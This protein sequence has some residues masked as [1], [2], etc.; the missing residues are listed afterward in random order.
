MQCAESVLETGLQKCGEFLTFF[1]CESWI[2]M[3]CL[4]ILQVYLFMRHI[5][6]TAED[7]RLLLVL[8][9]NVAQEVVFPLH[10]VV[11]AFQSVLSVG[12]IYCDEEEVFIL[13]CYNSSLMV[14]FF[15]ADAI[16]N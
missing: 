6:V 10:A 8:F 3:V 11:K 13:Q 4:R 7:N 9:F 14:M 5:K 16:A 2:I 1:V 15:Y 12:D